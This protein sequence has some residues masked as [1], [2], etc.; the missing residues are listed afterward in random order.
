MMSARRLERRTAVMLAGPSAEPAETEQ[1]VRPSWVISILAV[2]ALVGVQPWLH[3]A[4]AATTYVVNSTSDPGDGICDPQECTLREAVAGANTDG[5]VSMITFSIGEGGL[6]TI[7]PISSLPDITAPVTI[8]A[9]TQPGFAGAPIIELSGASAGTANGL[10]ITGGSSTVKGLVINRFR[11][12]GIELAGA[13]GNRLEGNYIGIDASGTVD[14]GNAITGVLIRGS[15]SNIVGGTAERSRNVISGNGEAGIHI[16]C[17]TTPNNRIEGNYIGTDAT[18]TTDLGN[19]DNGVWIEGSL[20]T[21][22]GGTAVGAGNVISGNEQAG[23]EISFS[24]VGI[25]APGNKV[26]G[27]YIG[28]DA[29]GT[30]DLGNAGDGVYIWEADSNTVGGSTTAARNVISGN[31]GSGVRIF[32]GSTRNKVEG[33]Y[34]GTDATGTAEIGNRAAGVAIEDSSSNIVGGTAA[35][36]RNVI[37]GNG[38]SGVLI[39]ALAPWNRTSGNRIE[40]NYIGAAANGTTDLGNLGNGVAILGGDSNTVGGTATGAG[41][42]VSG[43]GR[44]GIV[45]IRGEATGNRVERNFVGTNDGIGIDLDPSGVTE[46]DPGDPDGGA[47]NLQNFPVVSSASSGGGGTTVRGTLNSTPGT[48]FTLEF[49]SNSA[50]DGS[51]HGEGERFLGSTT[52]LTDGGGNA[53]F[54]ASFPTAVPTGQFVTATA[55]DPSGNTSE[56]SECRRVRRSSGF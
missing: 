53:N 26:E 10:R 18:G 36:A 55:T 45:I 24:F 5:D 8:D 25:S 44:T 9:T 14:L 30:A 50:C 29:S 2:L 16:V 13:G 19:S 1:V 31:S 54:T 28:T 48:R 52:L 51:G 33:N 32:S 3:P 56:F 49:F 23:V 47:N 15:H 41:N 46:N 11:G 42:V 39:H 34:I 27:N 22:V 12:W 7:S 38:H 43:N 20:S 40:G 35:G 21:V 17:C 4:W 6:Q 37:S